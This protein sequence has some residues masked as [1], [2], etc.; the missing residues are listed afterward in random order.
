MDTS[1]SVNDILIIFFALCKADRPNVVFIV[2]DDLRP[3]LGC[4]G[5]DMM[6]TPNVDNLAKK[7]VRFDRA[8]AQQAF[9]GPSRTSFLT[10]RRPDTT[11]LYDLYSYWR[12]HAGNYTSLP[13][14]FKDNGYFTQ[15]VGKVFHPGRAS[16]FTDDYP[17]SWSVPAYHPPTEKYREARVCPG[18]DGKLHMNVV[19][20]V[21]VSEMPGGSLPDLQ[22]SEFA[23][24]FL[25]NRTSQRQQPFFLAVGFHKPHLPLKYPKEYLDLYPM[26]EIHMATNPTFPLWLP[27]VAWNPWTDLRKRDDVKA[28]NVSFPFGPLPPAF[29]LKVRQSYYAATSYM[30][31]QVGKVL[32]AL[33]QFGFADNTVIVFLGDHGWSLGEHQEWSKFSNFEVATRVP[34]LFY[35]PGV[36]SAVS[37]AGKNFAFE[38][39]L[40]SLQYSGAQ[41]LQAY[42]LHQPSE[43]SSQLMTRL[44]K[45]KRRRR[46][47]QVG[48]FADFSESQDFARSMHDRYRSSLHGNASS[49]VRPYP[50]QEYQLPEGRGWRRIFQGNVMPFITRVN[51][52]ER[53]GKV[54][55]ASLK[56]RL[57]LHVDKHSHKSGQSGESP[58]QGAQA[59][60][61]VAELVDIFPTLTE[62][63]GLQ[64][65]PTCPP[66]PF[67]VTLCTEGSSLV[68]V[69]KNVSLEHSKGKKSG[70]ARSGSENI[71]RLPG[72]SDLSEWKDVAFSQF[73]RPSVE[74]EANSDKPHLKDI[75]IMG[76]TMRTDLY[77]YTE[78]VGFDPESFIANWSQVF[79]TELYMH[80]ADPSEDKN[81][82][83]FP[84][85]AQL[86]DKLSA[87]LRKGWRSALPW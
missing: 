34:L 26:S 72:R 35:V 75:R 2:V 66:D 27:V 18:A 86:V 84:Q 44:M 25:K 11:R 13:Q 59:T 76:Y 29:Q 70:K 23:V 8:Y 80:E 4:Y 50:P 1:C 52:V 32:S 53:N 57:S 58:S 39:P 68:P 81:V 65:P 74:P 62:L 55:K 24:Q 40:D 3:T 33:D 43:I 67:N 28:L 60:R 38:D 48:S 49:Y 41:A 64:V 31:A 83:S 14:H 12:S 56:Y 21:T 9:C 45:V 37:P 20:P 78:W 42:S 85:Y 19:C 71:R 46:K 47:R 7:S 63:A 73:P 16:N 30:D 5:N 54:S 10:G 51:T 15:S 17:L 69:I 77:R 6:L 87:K 22:S 82:A 36:T 61:A 79:A